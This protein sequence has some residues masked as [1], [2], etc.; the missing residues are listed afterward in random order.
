MRKCFEKIKIPYCVSTMK[1]LIEYASDK[2]KDKPAVKYMNN[3][4]VASISY[5]ELKRDVDLVARYLCKQNMQKKNIAILAGASYEWIVTLYG[6]ATCGGV[7]VP[8]DTGLSVSE[9]IILLKKADIKC[10][11]YDKLHNSKILEIKKQVP[12]IKLCYCLQDEGGAESVHTILERAAN[13]NME[14]PEVKADDLA[15]IVF[16]SGTTGSSKGVMLTHRNLCDNMICS[17]YLVGYEDNTATIPLLPVHHMFEFTTGIQ[18]VIFVG[19]PI[20]IGR[21]VKYLNESIQTFKPSVLILVPMI[22]EALHKRI[23]MEARKSGKEKQLKKVVKLSRFCMKFG[24]DL[25]KKLFKDIIAM[26]GGNLHTIVCGGAP[27]TKE[28]EQEFNDFGITLLNGYGITECSPVVAVNMRGTSRSG[29]VGVTSPE[30]YCKVKIQDGEILVSGSIVM[31]G[32]YNES[33]LT[34]KVF[35]GE[36]LKTGDLGYFD[37]DGFLFITGRRKSLIILDN[38]EN[39]SPEELEEKIARYDLVKEVM[40]YAKRNKM[41]M[42]ITALVVPDKK[43]VEENQIENIRAEVEKEIKKINAGLPY[44]KRIQVVEMQDKDLVKTTTGKVKRFMLERKEQ[45]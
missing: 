20:C 21:G 5:L 27:L 25:R 45:C 23:W 41:K 15:C 37:K 29:S 28:L 9:I 22:L 34:E 35:D 43:Y 38:G 16:T 18:T 33:E 42:E 2:Y 1:Q 40:V 11:F 3:G 36:W 14:L 44:Y 4:E 12:S 26:F 39:V 7:T 17:Y 6:I 24:I 8:I 10:I 32:Y 30:P 13:L 31:K 19:T